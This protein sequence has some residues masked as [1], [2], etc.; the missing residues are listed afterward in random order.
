MGL[1][2]EVASSQWSVSGGGRRLV[3]LLLVAVFPV[4]GANK[5][6]AARPQLIKDNYSLTFSTSSQLR[7]AATSTFKG[8]FRSSADVMAWR[9]SPANLGISAAGAS[10]TNSSWI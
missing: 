10:N 5:T 1:R 6:H 8:T 4:A 3:R 7:P 9:T 2:K